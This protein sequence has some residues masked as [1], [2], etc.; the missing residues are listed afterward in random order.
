MAPAQITRDIEMKSVRIVL[1]VL[2]ACA[3]IAFAFLLFA[4]RDDPRPTASAATKLTLGGPFTLTDARGQ[5]YGSAQLAGTPY[6]IFFGFTHC[7]D[8]CPTTLARLARLRSQAGGGETTPQILFVTV[9]PE[10]DGPAE[11][12]KY[13]QLFGS[14]VVGLTGSPAEIEQVKKQ[15]GIFSRKVPDDSGGYTVDHS[16]AALLFDRQGKFV[17][18]IVPEEPDSAALDKIKRV[19]SDS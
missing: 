12:G 1:W 6:V 7:P 11:V 4:R 10:R 14:P 18:T 17:A 13:G 19:V 15:F 2:V 16:A 8:V 5:R 9:D 3:A